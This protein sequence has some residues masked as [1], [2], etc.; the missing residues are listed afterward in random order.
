MDKRKLERKNLVYYLKVVDRSTGAL[1]GKLADVSTEGIMLIHPSPLPVG[2]FYAL[3]IDI[4]AHLEVKGPIDFD[5]ECR[6]SKPDVNP[7]F[8]AAG[9]QFRNI[10]PRDIETLEK[11]MEVYLL[12]K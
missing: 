2:T 9:L 4:P 10:L 11:L 1:V 3:R 7:D 12:P 6:W 8:F 5:A